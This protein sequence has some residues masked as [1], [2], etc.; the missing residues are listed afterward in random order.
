MPTIALEKRSEYSSAESADEDWKKDPA[1]LH[2]T[3]ELCMW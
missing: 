2:G 3:T 1:K